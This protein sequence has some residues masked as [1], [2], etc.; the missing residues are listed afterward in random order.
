MIISMYTILGS[1]RLYLLVDT[2]LYRIE[3]HLTFGNVPIGKAP[4]PSVSR[5]VQVP[6]YLPYVGSYNGMRYCM[7]LPTLKPFHLKDD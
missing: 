6:A 5:R 3:K 1:I 4:I 7:G 2:G